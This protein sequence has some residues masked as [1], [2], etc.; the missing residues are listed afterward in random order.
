MPLDIIV[1]VA[2]A[3]ASD[4]AFVIDALASDVFNAVGVAADPFDVIVVVAPDAAVVVVVAP[5]VVVVVAPDA[6]AAVAAV[7]VAV[8]DDRHQTTTGKGYI[9]A[10]RHPATQFEIHC[11]RPSPP[12]TFRTFFK[13]AFVPSS[14]HRGQ[15]NPSL[16]NLL[17]KLLS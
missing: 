6:V 2:F 9:L 4:A 3:A 17:I 10:K 14:S 7:F 16:L 12:K 8:V 1:S 5:D 15:K 11:N 13:H